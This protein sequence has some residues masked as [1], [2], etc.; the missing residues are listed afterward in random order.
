MQIFVGGLWSSVTT[1][2]LDR[3]VREL[4]RGPWYKLHVPRGKLAD[5]KLLRLTDRRTGRS[6]YC[7]LIAVEPRRMAWEVVHRMDGAR[8]HGRA[9]RA[10]R[11]F[12]RKGLADRRAMAISDESD[13]AGVKNRRSGRDRRRGLDIHALNRSLTHAVAGFERSYGR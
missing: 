7:A 5:C 11:W 3:L 9:L 12:E 4:L 6:E 2:D 1:H 10:H 8:L 13:D